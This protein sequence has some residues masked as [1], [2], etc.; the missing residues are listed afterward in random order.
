MSVD[1]IRAQY[2]GIQV[3]L[4]LPDDSGRDYEVYPGRPYW[5]TQTIDR[6]RWGRGR[7]S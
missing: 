4:G 5:E 2:L 3:F 6:D 1:L 7:G